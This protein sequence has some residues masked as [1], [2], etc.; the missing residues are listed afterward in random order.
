MDLSGIKTIVYE[1][2]GQDSH[3]SIDLPL[4]FEETVFGVK[5]NSFRH[6]GKINLQDPYLEGQTPIVENVD[7]TWFNDPFDGIS[8]QVFDVDNTSIQKFIDPSDK[9]NYIVQG[10]NLDYV[11]IRVQDCNARYNRNSDNTGSLGIVYRDP[12]R[13]WIF[14]DETQDIGEIKSYLHS[15]KIS[16]LYPSC[17]LNYEN[18][19]YREDRYIYFTTPYKMVLTLYMKSNN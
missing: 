12:M 10:D 18:I 8:K 2:W 17:L 4:S 3:F 5:L 14:D 19:A 11:V 6:N 1:Q 16:L 7:G 9:M 13:S 15:L